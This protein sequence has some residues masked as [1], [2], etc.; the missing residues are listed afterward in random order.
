MTHI[1]MDKIDR[2]VRKV[3]L[4]SDRMGKNREITDGRERKMII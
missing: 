2:M 4:A 1:V 3:E